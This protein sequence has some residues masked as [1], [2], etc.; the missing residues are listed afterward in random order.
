MQATQMFLVADLQRKSQ[1]AGQKGRLSPS[2]LPQNAPSA[3]KSRV[4]EAASSP[5]R[6]GIAMI[7]VGLSLNMVKDIEAISAQAA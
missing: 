3:Q 2:P 1:G 7:V 5:L 6:R 4:T